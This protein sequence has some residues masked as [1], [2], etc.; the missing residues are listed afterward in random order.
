MLAK[1]IPNRVIA[2][3][4][5]IAACPGV[6]G[7]RVVRGGQ[8]VERIVSVV[9]GGSDAARGGPQQCH[10]RDGGRAQVDE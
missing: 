9:D 1:T 10:P 3:M 2:V 6:I 7:V 5:V 4:V 8:A